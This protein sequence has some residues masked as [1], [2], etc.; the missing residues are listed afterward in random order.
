[1]AFIDIDGFYYEGEKGD[2]NDIQVPTRPTPYHKYDLN[3]KEWIIDDKK[4][5]DLKKRILS[6]LDEDL[7]AKTLLLNLN[8]EQKKKVQDRYDEQLQLLSNTNDPIILQE[9][10][11]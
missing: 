11:L 3:L 1:M 5:L 6:Q 8:N 2:I 10:T 4:V 7:K 9:I